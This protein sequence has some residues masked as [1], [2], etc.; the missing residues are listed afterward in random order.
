M[1]F[2]DIDELEETGKLLLMG[3]TNPQAGR[4]RSLARLSARLITVRSRVQIASGPPTFLKRSSFG[5]AFSIVR[6]MMLVEA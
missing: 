3:S 4:A 6:L 1:K 2:L 5:Y